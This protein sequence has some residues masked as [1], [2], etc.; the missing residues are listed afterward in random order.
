MSDGSTSEIVSAAREAVA[1]PATPVADKIEMLIAIATDLQTQPKTE[2]ELHSAI[3]LYTQAEA[4][5]P[6]T[7]RLLAARI[8]ARKGT[9]LQALPSMGSE[10]LVAAAAAL[11]AAAPVLESSGT[12]EEYAELEMNLG[13][14]LQ[15]LTSYSQAR[16]T[17]AIAAY[18]RALRTFT[19]EA[20]PVEFAIIHNNLAT[21]YLSIP[22]TDERAKMREALA[23][24]SFE[25]ALEVVT[26]VDHPSEY[27]M[28]QNNLGNAL[29]YASSSHA[30]EN[31]LRAIAAYDA[32]LQVRNRR[33]NPLPYANTISNKANALRN[34]PDDPQQPESPNHRNLTAAL[35]LYREAER[36]FVGSGDVERGHMVGEAATEIA[37]E[38]EALGHAR[39]PDAG[40]EHEF[41]KSR[42][43]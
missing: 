40:R 38:L 33:D 25:H 41:G 22:L 42:V 21:A 18:H 5:C 15:S 37:A 32:A 24:Q 12:A 8:A 43:S 39:P 31:N 9:A 29:Q 4:L 1:N 28:L 23:V 20:H 35:A 30:V 6:E 26:L 16:I 11:R 14:V 34:L 19:R 3:E 17:D 7:D 2:R 10:S 36:I 13:L 27:A